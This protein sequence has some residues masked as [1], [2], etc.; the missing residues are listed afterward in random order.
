M[1]AGTGL[2]L[3]LTTCIGAPLLP[4]T[5]HPKCSRNGEQPLPS[6]FLHGFGCCSLVA[7]ATSGE[8]WAAAAAGGAQ[9]WP[10]PCCLP[11]ASELGPAVQKRDEEPGFPH[12]N[13]KVGICAFFFG[14]WK[15]IG[16]D[17]AFL[18]SFLRHR[19]KF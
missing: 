10:V 18:G 12:P 11:A 8:V 13:S 7:G 15:Q 5:Q 2:A 14:E 6:P 9:W 3:T 19:L 17:R 4:G 16:F 1:Q